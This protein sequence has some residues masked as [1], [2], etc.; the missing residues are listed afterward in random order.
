MRALVVEDDFTSCLLLQQ[1]LKRFAEVRIAVDGREAVDAALVAWDARLP[2]HLICLDIM[3]PTLD[4]QAA[5]AE[6]RA[7]EKRLGIE[8][9]H[10]A[11]IIMTTTLDDLHQVKMAVDNL[12]SGYLTKPIDKGAFLAMMRKLELIA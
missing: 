3:M 6:L 8:P 2:Y 4:G 11:A 12:C 10:Q 9:E 5:L 1:I 7:H